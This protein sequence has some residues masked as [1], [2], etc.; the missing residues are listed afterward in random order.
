MQIAVHLFAPV[1]TFAH[2]VDDAI[3][4]NPFFVFVIA[5]VAH[6]LGEGDSFAGDFHGGILARYSGDV[7]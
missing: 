2:V 3:V 1:G 7:G 5:V 6:E 4:G